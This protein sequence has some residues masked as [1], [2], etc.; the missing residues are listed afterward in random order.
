MMLQDIFII[1]I[2]ALIVIFSVVINSVLRTV[3]LCV[4]LNINSP[5]FR[6]SP[7]L[8]QKI[9]NTGNMPLAFFI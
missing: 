7:S 5:D 3:L 8:E 4:L 6:Q 1:L 2:Q 9:I